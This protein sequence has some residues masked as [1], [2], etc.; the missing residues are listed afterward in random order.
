[1]KV[2][3][4]TK[5]EIEQTKN[6]GS[7]DKETSEFPWSYDETETCYI[8]EGE[9]IATNPEGKEIRFGSGDMVQFEKGLECTWKILKDIK[10]RYKFG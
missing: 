5:K 8:L 9:A 7:W 1:M 3:K 6:W 2:W 4:P 10:K